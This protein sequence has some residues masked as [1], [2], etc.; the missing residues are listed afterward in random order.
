MDITQHLA[1]NYWFV[2][3]PKPLQALLLSAATIKHYAKGTM[4]HAVG[5]EGSAFFNVVSGTVRICNVGIEGYGVTLT[6]LTTGDWFGEISILDDL[7]RS[8]DAWAMDDV[9]IISIAKSSVLNIAENHP[10]LYKHLALITCQRIRQAFSLIN[11][12]T[13]L[14]TPQRLANRLLGLIKNYGEVG[15]EGIKINLRLSQEE[16]GFMLGATRQTIN[17]IMKSWEAQSL[18]RM[19]YG[20]ITITNQ[21]EFKKLAR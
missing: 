11:D 2:A 20:I 4:I 14:D 7:P 12:A 5:D 13:V 18:I 10:I 19:H 9:I 15:T 21:E 1:N 16:L 3:M 17:K 8:H 6:H